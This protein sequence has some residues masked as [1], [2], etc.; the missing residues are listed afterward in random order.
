MSS[1]RQKTTGRY[2]ILV[3]MFHG[4]NVNLR[5]KS[6][7]YCSDSFFEYYI[8]IKKTLGMG[9]SI[10][11]NALTATKEKAAQMGYALR[12]S[13]EI[14]I[15]KRLET[16]D[17]KYHR[18]LKSRVEGLKR[19]IVK[20]YEATG[21]HG[22]TSAWLQDVVDSCTHPDRIKVGEKDF[23]SLGEEYLRKHH[24]AESD[25]KNYCVLLRAVARYEAFVKATERRTFSFD[26]DRLKRADIED[27][28]DYFRHEKSISEH[29]PALFADILEAHPANMKIKKQV[30]YDHGENTVIK[31][32][33]RLKT[34][35]LWFAENGLTHNRPF[36]GIEIGAERY[37]TPYY[38]TIEERNKIAE[39]DMEAAFAGLSEDEKNNI[40]F[41]LPTLEAQRDVFVCHCFIGC[42]V[43]DL[44]RMSERNIT[45]GILVYTPIK[46]HNVTDAV[47]ARVPLH[48]KALALIE[49]YRGVDIEGRLFPFLS[50]YQYNKAIKQ[51]FTLCGITRSVEVR[52]PLTGETELRPINEIASSHLARRTF[53][54]NAYFKVSDPNIIGKMSGHK[55]GSRAFRRYRNIEDETLKGVIDQIG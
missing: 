20:R 17:V 37:G 43:S 6:G 51:I 53:I 36:N 46:T 50:P 15:T 2:E 28:I 24:I 41:P 8:D 5:A 4:K 16:P 35:F 49:K 10:A 3:R 33:K 31:N 1:R 39:T 9:V 14:V 22:L 30:I 29:H 11:G 40:T 42:R 52:N 19:Y 54:G 44:I 38:I 48:P 23:Y 45:N 32:V 34:L 55:D 21:A 13:G 18:E 25:A 12:Q 47:Q 27:F 7:W 26:I